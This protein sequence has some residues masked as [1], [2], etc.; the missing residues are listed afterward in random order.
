MYRSQ[1][2][3]V[4]DTASSAL[5]RRYKQPGLDTY[6]L[7]ESVLLTPK[8]AEE[9]SAIVQKYPELCM[10]KLVVQLGM[11]RQQGFPSAKLEDFAK[12]LV[13]MTGA[14][15]AMFQQIEVMVKLLLTLPCSSAEA[16]RSFSAMRR[17]KTYLRGTMSQD[18]LNNLAI[19]HVHRDLVQAVDMRLVANDFVKLNE[20]RRAVFGTFQT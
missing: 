18:R 14:M 6:L 1:Y 12:T 10:E 13:G 11:Y 20:K 17:L 4:V 5:E 8:V 9:I 16:E 2:F 3:Q 19:L 7:L 15:R